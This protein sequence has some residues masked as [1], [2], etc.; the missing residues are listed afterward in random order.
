MAI[1]GAFGL[2][3]KQ[4]FLACH[5]AL[6]QQEAISRM[7]ERFKKEFGFEITVRMGINK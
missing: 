4:S 5:A 7:N 6:L 2:E 1:W 3:S